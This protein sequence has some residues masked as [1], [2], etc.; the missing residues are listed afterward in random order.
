M[1]NT[2]SPFFYLTTTLPYVNAEPHLGFAWEILTADYI[3]RF[4][5]LQG[6]SVIFSTGTDEHGQKIWEKAC[7]RKLQPQTYVDQMVTG[8]LHLKKALDLSWTNF[9]RTTATKHIVAAQEMWRRCSAAGDIYKKKYQVKYCI[10]CE[11]EKTDSELVNGR[12]PLHP[13]QEIELRAEDNYFFR[14]SKYQQPLLDLYQRQSDFVLGAGKMTEI[15]KFVSAGLQDFSISRVK[16]KMPW[17]ISVPGDEEQVMYVWFDALSSYI[18]TL[19]WPNDKVAFKQNWPVT[20]ICGKDN[21]RQQAAM[22][23][24]MLMSAGLAPSKQIL[25]NGFITIAGQKMSK[26]LGN[27]VSPLDLVARYGVD[28]TRFVLASLPVLSQDVDVTPQR[29]DEFYQANLAHGIGNL[30]SRLARLISLLP[31]PLKLKQ[32]RHVSTK[33]SAQMTNYLTHAALAEIIKVSQEI[34]LTLSQKKPWIISDNRQKSQI[35][36]PLGQRFV[37]MCFDLQIFIPI[38]ANILLQHFLAAKIIPLD[39]LFPRLQKIS[40]Q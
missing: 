29:L 40:T 21:L 16:A 20:Q 4:K 33:V 8:F 36:Q 22:W 5:R 10:G 12:C 37:Q 7:A 13:N 2:T 23:Q 30:A 35:L 31:Q 6:Q 14:F 9:L 39:P 11:L 26:S 25:V 34:D 32:P 19:G 38:T 24:A 1:S 3:C 15:T 28:G 17:G 18:S 27:V